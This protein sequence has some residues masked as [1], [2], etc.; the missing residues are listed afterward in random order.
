[1]AG[2]RLK[3]ALLTICGVLA[4]NEVSYMLIGGTAVA[5]N[6]YY[7]PSVNASGEVAD[8]PDID[9]WYSPTY[10]NYFKMLKALKEL[11]HDVQSLERAQSPNPR[12]S[13]LKLEFDDFTF[14]LLPQIKAD[15]SFGEAYQR[16]KTFE[17][18]AVSLNVISVEDLILDK[19][20]TGRPK[21]LEDIKHLEKLRGL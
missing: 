21:D 11:G 5:L 6:G 1:M 13:F 10:A 14:D 15:I 4:K 17:L 3:D 20:A 19:K 16:K 12:K 9:L 2:N 18:N 7:R 8:K